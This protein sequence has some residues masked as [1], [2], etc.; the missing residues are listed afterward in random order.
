MSYHYNFNYNFNLKYN[1]DGYFNL[2]ISSTI[3]YLI[4]F[5][6]I[7]IISSL[8]YNYTISNNHIIYK[9]NVTFVEKLY[10]INLKNYHI[11]YKN[12]N[13]YDLRSENMILKYI[14]IPIKN[15]TI[16]SI[17]TTISNNIYYE[18][19]NDITNDISYIININDKYILIDTDIYEL[20]IK[21]KFKYNNQIW[22]I[23]NNI[24]STKRLS[25]LSNKLIYKELELHILIYC[26]YSNIQYDKDINITK[27]NNS[28]DSNIIDY[29]KNNI[30]NGTKKIRKLTA[31]K[32]PPELS[33]I[34]LPKYVVYYS[35]F[36]NNYKKE[37]F[38]I[39]NHPK[40]IKPWVST[41]KKNTTIIDK[42]NETINKLTTLN[43]N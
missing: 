19:Q 17:P 13:T 28:L 42:Y 1:N 32:L 22:T 20:L 15:I 33:N 11:I 9:N 23:K 4:D 38:K 36:I 8:S 6:K 16:I 43:D 34:Q 27:F 41:T 31:K 25:H 40:L 37:Y 29:T 14:D 24:V 26:F 3:C 7:D 21:S 10:N 30:N 12:K 39:E 18:I 5:N 35:E 2:Y